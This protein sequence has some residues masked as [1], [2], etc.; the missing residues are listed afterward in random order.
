MNA[1]RVPGQRTVRVSIFR[2]HP[3]TDS[4]ARHDAFRLAAQP[5][6][7]VLDALF[8]VL[9]ETDPTLA[10]RCSCRLGMCG[11]C[12]MIINGR[13]RLACRTR[14]ETLGSRITLKPLRNLP[15]IKDLVVDMAPFFEAWRRI[16]PAF[17]P[18]EPAEDAGAQSPGPD[19]A[20]IPPD[21]KSRGIIEQGMDCI[22]CGACYSACTMVTANPDFLGPAALNRAYVLIQDERDGDGLARLDTVSRETGALRCHTLFDCAAVCPKGII[23]TWSIQKLKQQAVAGLAGR[24]S[25]G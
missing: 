22:T 13:E 3:D 6:M 23:P 2:F 9:R 1:S 16:Q 12:A 14:L 19:F 20:R 25:Q 5:E 10:F 11:S 7:T 15:I 18:A 4:T 24:E 17:R 8:H 21:A